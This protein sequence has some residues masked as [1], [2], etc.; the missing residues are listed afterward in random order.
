MIKWD[1]N[2]FDSRHIVTAACADARLEIP[3]DT[4][5]ERI[6]TIATGGPKN[7]YENL[8]RRRNI[9]S[10]LIL[11]HHGEG[12]QAVALDG[13]TMGQHDPEN[14]VFGACPSNGGGS[15]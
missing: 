15:N 13:I 11:V 6:H 5:N 12:Y 2:R 4:Y 10:I 1:I 3:I 9:S 7:P 8:L 14:Q